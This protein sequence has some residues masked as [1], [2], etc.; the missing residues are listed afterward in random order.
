MKGVRWIAL[1]LAAVL[2]GGAAFA[3]A[4]WLSALLGLVAAYGIVR[5]VLEAMPKRDPYSL[6]SLDE[7]EEKEELRRLLEA[8]PTL[9]D[10]AVAVC[11]CCHGLAD[12]KT[13]ICRG[14]GR[15]L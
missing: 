4:P 13:G 10:E 1:I 9:A 12:K 2:T 3:F 5:Y 14:C 11:P 15:P 8:E 6:A 7:F